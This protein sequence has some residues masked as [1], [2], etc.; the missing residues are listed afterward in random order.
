MSEEE[1]HG[2]IVRGVFVDRDIAEYTHLYD[3][4]IAEAER[5]TA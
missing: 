3:Q 2:K 1:K 5:G 4:I